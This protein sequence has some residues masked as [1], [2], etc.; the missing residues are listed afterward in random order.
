MYLRSIALHLRVILLRSNLATDS[1]CIRIYI[2]KGY[3][4]MYTLIY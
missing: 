1:E 4:V 2:F 3:I